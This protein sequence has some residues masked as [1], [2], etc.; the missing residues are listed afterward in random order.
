MTK[1]LSVKGMRCRSC[2]LLL[3]DVLGT[4]RGVHEVDVD[5]QQGRVSLE[6]DRDDV[7][8]EVRREIRRHGYSIAE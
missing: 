2:E 5:M 3:T 4:I 7:L 8:D 1:I 6:V